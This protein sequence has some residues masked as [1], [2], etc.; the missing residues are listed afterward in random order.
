MQY[1]NPWSWSIGGWLISSAL[2]GGAAIALDYVEHR[3]FCLLLMNLRLRDTNE[4]NVKAEREKLRERER[5]RVRN[6][7]CAALGAHYEA[8]LSSCFFFR[9]EFGEFYMGGL[10]FFTWTK[11]PL[12]RRF[13]NCPLR[14][15][16]TGCYRCLPTLFP[17]NFTTPFLNCFLKSH[18]LKMVMH[19]IRVSQGLVVLNETSWFCTF[20]KSDSSVIGRRESWE[21]S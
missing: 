8:K 12:A 21:M 3:T 7:V 10:G 1:S 19:W 13:P 18:W 11:V 5:E 15:F 2:A 14:N 16:Q 4:S 20:W 9:F 6:N 17:L